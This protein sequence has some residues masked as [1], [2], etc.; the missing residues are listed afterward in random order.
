LQAGTK[1]LTKTKPQ[2]FMRTI[3]ITIYSF[4]ELTE[5]AKQKALN[6]YQCET[7]YS[8]EHEAFDSLE[9]FFKAI[10]VKMRNFCIDWLCPSQS[11]IRY[12]GTPTGKF[13]PSN[14][15]GVCFDY[16]LV[17]TWNKTKSVESSINAFLSFCQKDFECQLSEESFA[18][19]CDA[20]EI[21]FDQQGNRI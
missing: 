12:E 13:I 7:E 5:K 1:I 11:F 21:Y 2:K 3:E 6:K 15:T 16:E 8:W 4:N 9:A 14:L 19:Y 17:K 20:N 10:G 18:D